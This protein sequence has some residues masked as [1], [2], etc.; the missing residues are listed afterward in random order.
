M[1]NEYD[2]TII[3]LLPPWIDGREV[4]KKVRKNKHNNSILIISAKDQLEN[5]INGLN[6]G[7]DDYLIKPFAFDELHAR[8]KTL[9]RRKYDN[10]SPIIRLG[11]M[12]IDTAMRN[13]EVDNKALTL[14]PKEYL[15]VEYLSMNP[16]RVISYEGLINQVYASAEEVSLNALEAHVSAIR[17]KLKRAGME[18]FLK[19]KRGFGYFVEKQ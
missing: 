19:N 5:R 4:L 14:T 16:G 11:E 10:K 6:L 3:D 1:I 12:T 13:I 7:A 9:V 8:L 18:N 2:V 17:K 15:I